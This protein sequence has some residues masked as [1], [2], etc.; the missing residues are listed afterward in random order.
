MRPQLTQTQST[1]SANADV[2]VDVFFHGAPPLANDIT[3]R[4]ESGCVPVHGIE[5]DLT[6]WRMQRGA[7]TNSIVSKANFHRR[8]NWYSPAMPLRHCLG[9]APKTFS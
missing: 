4:V 3:H 1:A 8:V 2:V 7:R 5:C 6:S 9:R